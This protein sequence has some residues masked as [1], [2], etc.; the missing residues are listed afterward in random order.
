MREESKCREECGYWHGGR[1]RCLA[2]EFADGKTLVVAKRKRLT[3]LK[4][5]TKG[6]RSDGE[7]YSGAV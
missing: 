2:C 6:D 3:W 1:R 7:G 4:V 5:K